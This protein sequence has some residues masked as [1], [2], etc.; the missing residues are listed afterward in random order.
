[1]SATSSLHRL[2]LPLCESVLAENRDYCPEVTPR[3]RVKNVLPREGADMPEETQMVVDPITVAVV[4]VGLVAF[5]QTK[6]RLKVRRVGGKTDIEFAIS[7]D[8]AS[9]ETIKEV[10]TAV[11]GVASGKSLD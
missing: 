1:M 2:H 4:L 10:L 11:G 7:K 9:D 3:A 8:A 5:L 6:F